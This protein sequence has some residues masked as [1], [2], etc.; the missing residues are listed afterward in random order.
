M[1]TS[2]SEPFILQL[3]LCFGSYDPISLML[4]VL[5]ARIVSPVDQIFK[6]SRDHLCNWPVAKSTSRVGE[7]IH[8][9]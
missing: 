4:V 1:F 7:C 6:I 3:P 2:S 9:V 8:S 5:S